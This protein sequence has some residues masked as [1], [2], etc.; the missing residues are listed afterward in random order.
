MPLLVFVFFR[1][2]QDPEK[3][4]FYLFRRDKGGEV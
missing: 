4:S 1:R 3:Q 2:D